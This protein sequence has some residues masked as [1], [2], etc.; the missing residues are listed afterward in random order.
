LWYNVSILLSTP[1]LLGAVSTLKLLQQEEKARVF[2]RTQFIDAQSPEARPNNGSAPPH[3]HS[4]A[5][6]PPESTRYNS[7]NRI[8]RNSFKTK[9][10]PPFY[11]VQI[12]MCETAQ[13]RMKSEGNSRSLVGQTAA[14]VGMT[15]GEVRAGETP[16]PPHSPRRRER[17]GKGANREIGV[18]GRGKRQRERGARRSR[19]CCCPSS[20]AAGNTRGNRRGGLA[21]A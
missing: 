21:W 15:V 19:W 8:R 18:P 9:N 16:G 20:A 14:S 6:Q 5:L 3:G 17:A 7:V 2:L 1:I 4:Y 10:R 12:R 13:N 11:P